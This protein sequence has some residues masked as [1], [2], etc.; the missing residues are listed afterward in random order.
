MTLY[1]L[2]SALDDYRVT[3]FTKDLDVE[4]SYLIGNL[5]YTISGAFECEC[6]AGSR[7]TCRHRQ[8]LKDLL[9]IV[10]TAFFWNFE[11]RMYTD[12]DGAQVTLDEIAES[13]RVDSTEP[14]IVDAPVSANHT[15]PTE[16]AMH[17][18]GR[19]EWRRI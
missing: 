3:K 16:P 14:A 15:Q 2:R 19:P 11:Q 17:P 13:A 10:D 6:P 18:D 12:S 4:S 8:M 5:G 1:N 7:S 9:L